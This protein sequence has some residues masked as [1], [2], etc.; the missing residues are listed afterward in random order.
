M[1]R[2]SSVHEPAPAAKASSA[3]TRC[4]R[5]RRTAKATARAA[6]L[7]ATSGRK[8]ASDRSAKVG[9]GRAWAAATE[10]R[11][12]RSVAT[13]IDVAGAIVLEGERPLLLVESNLELELLAAVGP[14]SLFL[15]N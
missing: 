3:A 1:R 4:D 7:E 12:W 2:E 9:E 14:G 13:E 5:W 15:G 11:P 8:A 6:S 10:R